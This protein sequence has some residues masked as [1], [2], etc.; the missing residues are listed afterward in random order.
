MYVYFPAHYVYLLTLLTIFE[1]W[2]KF[3]VEL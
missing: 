1:F 3:K 2:N